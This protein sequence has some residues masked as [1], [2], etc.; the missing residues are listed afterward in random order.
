MLPLGHRQPGLAGAA[1]QND[2]V[3]VEL[4]CDGVHV[5]PAVVRMTLAAKSRARVMA[6]SDGTA[7]AG[8]E[9]GSQARLGGRRIT[10]AETHAALDDGTMAGSVLTM[11]AVFQRLTSEMG[12]SLVDAAAMCATTPAR[13]L[14]LVGHGVLAEGAVAD[15]AVV[16]RSGRVV[17]TYVGGRLV[18]ARDGISGRAGNGESAGSV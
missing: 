2:D 8:L 9:P 18:H 1:L 7:V 12:V 5:H 10:A 4:I 3:V 17:Q 14:G 11:D 6:I 13:A 15:L 16:D